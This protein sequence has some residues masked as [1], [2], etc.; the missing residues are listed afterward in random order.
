MRLSNRARAANSAGQITNHMSVD[1]DKLEKVCSQLH[2]LWACPVKIVISVV[3]LC[4]ILHLG[5]FMGALVLAFFVPVQTRVATR[6]AKFA[7]VRVVQALFTRKC[8][9]RGGL[10]GSP[11][12]GR[13][14]KIDFPFA[15]F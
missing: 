6:L 7:K 15:G 4:R 11:T 12:K 14:I 2:Q 13:S 9:M 3:L 5:G 10:W 8:Y 1:A